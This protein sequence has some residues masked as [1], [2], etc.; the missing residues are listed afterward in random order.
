[1]KNNK[2]RV[3]AEAGIMVA[4]AFVLSMVIIYKLPWG[5]SVTLLSMLPIIVF[6]IRNGAVNGLGCAFVYSLTQLMQGIVSDGLLG[7][8]LTP[9]YLAACIFL[10]YIGAFT[11]LGLAGV[12]RK[13]G[14]KGWIG[15]SVIAIMYRYIFHVISGA[16]VFHSTGKLWEGLEF[17]NPWLY[18]LSYNAVFMLPEVILTTIGAVVL[19][20]SGA[21]KMILKN[22]EASSA[23]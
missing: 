6:S 19:F 17:N 22:K 14:V 21:V 15:G 20:K 1:M 13:F 5:G 3:L 11:V 8:G 12:F 18:S 7:W 2:V 10:D 16:A 9:G 4:L 23:V